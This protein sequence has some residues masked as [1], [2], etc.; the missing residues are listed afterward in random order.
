MPKNIKRVLIPISIILFAGCSSTI[1]R[2][3]EGLLQNN[4]QSGKFTDAAI[5]AEKAL[6]FVDSET[7][8][9]TDVRAT[10]VENALLHMNAAELQRLSGNKKRALAHY[11]VVDENLFQQLD[12][13]VITTGYE[14][15]PHEKVLTNFYKS[16]SYWGS[17]DV[18]NARIEFNRANERTRLAVQRY[19]KMINK[20]KEKAE[21]KSSRLLSISRNT[22]ISQL[23]SDW[24]VFDD[25]TNPVVTYMS[26]LFLASQNGALDST[27]KEYMERVQQMTK[28]SDIPASLFDLEDIEENKIWIIAETG[29]GP[30]LG[31]KRLDIPFTHKGKALILQ[32]A[33]PEVEQAQNNVVLSN[34]TINNKVIDFHNLTTMDKLVKTELKKR[35][36]GI[37]A[38]QAVQALGKAAIQYTAQK[39]GGAL[40][41]FLALAATS[42]ITGADTTIWKMTPNEWNIAK[43]NN[44]NEGE[45]EI[46]YGNSIQTIE[47]PN[48]SAIIYLKQPNPNAKPLIEIIEI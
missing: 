43:F 12:N 45:L 19:E 18:D 15:T 23:T 22:E 20:E 8:K 34:Y 10:K 16:I 33:F 31:E 25:F 13:E 47:M 37:I 30:T 7:G 9:M 46:R 42:A 14:P 29:Q 5:I 4:Y 36:P 39:E 48:K 32:M 38:S 41:G 26:S 27:A 40:G 35:W 2:D 24:E 1:S 28:D 17:G 44:P 6:G 3:D 11:N 21:K